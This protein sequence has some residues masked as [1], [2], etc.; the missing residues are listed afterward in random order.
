MRMYSIREGS[1]GVE[2]DKIG[3][4]GVVTIGSLFS[5]GGEAAK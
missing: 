3:F 5:C 4:S 2:E 1:R